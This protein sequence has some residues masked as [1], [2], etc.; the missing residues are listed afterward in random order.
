[1]TVLVIANPSATAVGLG[2]RDALIRTL[3]EISTVEVVNTSSRGHA[4]TLAG[5]AMRTRTADVV[6]GLGGDGTV[7]EIVNGL[8]ADGVH[9]GIP[10]LGVIPAGATNVFSR[11]LG[12]PNDPHAATVMLLESLRSGWYRNINLGRVDERYFVF[13]AGIGLDAAIIEQ[14]EEQRDLGR[15]STLFLTAATALSNLFS[16]RWPSLQLKLPSGLRID[17]LRWMIVTK[18]DPWT[19]I[20]NRPLRPTPHACF[21]LGMDIYA[22]RRTMPL[23]L[24]WSLVQMSRQPPRSPGRRVHRE[25]DVGEF[26]VQ[27][28]EPVPVHVDGDMLGR[29]RNLEFR[30]AFRALRVAAPMP[31]TWLGENG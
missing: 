21:E 26:A 28:E 25:H 8:L 24:L 15:K 23:G 19:F 9:G 14:V 6:I 29:R 20:N 30:C 5:D 12:F 22:R 18:T 10:A 16:E 2:Q 27:A 11:S 17:G 1:V 31:S 4:I 7:N 13:C 3:C